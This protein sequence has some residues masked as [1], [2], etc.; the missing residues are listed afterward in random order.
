MPIDEDD[1]D[2]FLPPEISQEA[3]SQKVEQLENQARKVGL[4][5]L[6]GGIIHDDDPDEIEGPHHQL[7]AQF[8][9]GD[10][11]F[12]D[13][14]QDPE[15]DETNDEFRKIKRAMVAEDIENLRQQYLKRKASGEDII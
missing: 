6:G 1:E 15:T 8:Q 7:V 4:Y 11:A 2:N 10:Q 5:L 14:V 3:M 12:S 13:R 9:I